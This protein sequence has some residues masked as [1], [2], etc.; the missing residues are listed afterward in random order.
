MGDGVM[1]KILE[2]DIAQLVGLDGASPEVRG[3]ALADAQNYILRAVVQ[4]V[5]SKL[6]PEADQEF[7][8]LFASED[9]AITDTN[10]AFLQKHVPSLDELVLQETL[11]F[12]KGV[13]DAVEEVHDK[14]TKESQK[15]EEILNG[16]G[17]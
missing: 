15:I 8:Q 16:L 11:A 10:M 12:K 9:D 5:R 1:K 14:A 7:V 13:I 6:S 4:C 17:K 2:T 3:R